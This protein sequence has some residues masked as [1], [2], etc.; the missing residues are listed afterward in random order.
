VNDRPC[1]RDFRVSSRAQISVSHPKRR[2]PRLIPSADFG[3]INAKVRPQAKMSECQVRNSF[4]ALEEDDRDDD[5]NNDV[6]IGTVVGEA[7]KLSRPSAMKFNVASV[8]KPLASAVKVVEAGNRI[9]MGPKP[10]DNYIENISTGEKLAIRVDRGTYVFDVEFTNGEGGTITLDSGAGVNV[11][12]QEMLPDLPL[13]AKE[14]GL[15]MTAA[16]GT[17][18]ANLGTKMVQFRGVAP[19]FTRRA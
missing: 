11:W 6:F 9:F 10:G 13:L 3:H 19:G 8:K 5:C 1:G 18:I 17:P 15:R 14:P 2:F 7:K 4:Q 12:P 16:N